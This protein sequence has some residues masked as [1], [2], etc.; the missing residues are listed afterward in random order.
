MITMQREASSDPGRRK[1]VFLYEAASR[2]MPRWGSW[3][4][5]CIELV[6]FTREFPA[7]WVH[8]DGDRDAEGTGKSNSQRSKAISGLKQ[9]ANPANSAKSV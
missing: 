2:V 5:G 8:A 7:G 4:D 9:P 3:A 1:R 6:Q